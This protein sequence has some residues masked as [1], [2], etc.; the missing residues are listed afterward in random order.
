[1]EKKESSLNLNLDNE[2]YEALTFAATASF[3]SLRKEATLRV[4]DHIH[5]FDEKCDV[6]FGNEDKKI[7]I[8]LSISDKQKIRPCLY[9]GR[10]RART[11]ADECSMR[12]KEHLLLFPY[13]SAIGVVMRNT[14]R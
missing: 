1:M 4:I 8:M 12:L 10:Y 9:R 6:D 5:R 13:I 7:K 3:R 11:L 2:A 14:K